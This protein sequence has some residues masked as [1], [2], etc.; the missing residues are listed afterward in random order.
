M[1]PSAAGAEPHS[2][3]YESEGLVR[4]TGGAAP[5]QHPRV[6][7]KREAG[8]AY[9][10]ERNVFREHEFGGAEA[11]HARHLRFESGRALR[12]Q[13]ERERVLE[14]ADFEVDG[15][16]GLSPARAHLQAADL[17]TA[18]EQTVKEEVNFQTTFNNNV[19]TLIARETV[20]MGLMHLW[21]F[22]EAYVGN[23]ASKA[24]MAQLFLIAQHSRDEGVL[25]EA[26][27][28]IAEPESRWL[29]DLLSLLQT[30]VVQERGMSLSEKVAAINYSVVTLSRHYARKIYRSLFVPIDKEAKINTFYM[31]AVIKLLTLSDDLG[32][33]R[34]ER[35]ERVVS[36]GRRRELSD[37]ELMLSLRRALAGQDDEED[38]VELGGDGSSGDELEVAD[39]PVSYPQHRHERALEPGEIG[40]HAGRVVSRRP[41]GRLS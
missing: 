22:V 10:P 3:G 20:T 39:Q 19:R 2:L 27:L 41:M 23:P 9:V 21:D 8:E 16:T 15:S 7:M 14:A 40:R 32:T 35:I 1:K 13:H 28:N 36:S 17:V 12:G 11:E 5:E 29:V 37:Q 26:L 30:I 33:Y 25:R 18:Y 6:Q 31:R 24:L 4:L 38:E 34:N